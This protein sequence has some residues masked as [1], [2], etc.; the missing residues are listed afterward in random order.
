[1]YNNTSM[2]KLNNYKYYK[3]FFYNFTLTGEFYTKSTDVIFNDMVVLPEKFSTW[4]IGDGFWSNPN[5][6]GNYIP[7]D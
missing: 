1:M 6:E 2:F 4:I 5:G 3:E 7:S